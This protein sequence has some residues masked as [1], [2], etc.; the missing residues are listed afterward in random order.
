MLVFGLA[1]P[2]AA[3]PV[4]VDLAQ[5]RLSAE[6]RGGLALNLAL[7]G[8]VPWRIVLLDNPPRLALDLSGVD[9]RGSDPDTLRPDRAPVTA[10][11]AGP[12]RPGWSRLVLDLSHPQEPRR[13]GMEVDAATGAAVL[14][15]TTRL[16]S[17][18]RFS[19]LIA[20]DGLDARDRSAGPRITTSEAG[21]VVV[22]DPGHGGIDPGAS[23]GGVEE[24]AVMLALAKELAAAIDAEPGMRAL[25]TRTEDVFVP[26]EAR[27]S[28]ARQAGADV[29]LS[30]H[31]DALELDQAAG[32][33]IYRLSRRAQESAAARMAERHSP[34]DLIAGLDL[35]GVGDGVATALM[36]LAW[37]RTEPRSAALQRALIA[38]L[39]QSGARLTARPERR[40][41]LAVLMA[42]DFPSVLIE[43]GF[44]SNAADRVALRHPEG[45]APIVAGIVAGLK[46]WQAAE[47]AP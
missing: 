16:V 18:E 20:Q 37:Q 15:L 34:A 36:D 45:R 30:L 17:A 41:K 5:S 11:R 42:A 32:A 27:M 35:S 26:L 46:A 31:A 22:L 14:H 9:W 44:L 19:E 3:A 10:L 8:A 43:A 29:F 12:L 33:S 1:A 2:L 23:R 39:G 13:A 7:E 4:V 25:L 28:L 40:A 38:A 24:A 21:L 47:A 6:G